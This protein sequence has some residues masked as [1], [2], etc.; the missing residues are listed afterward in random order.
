MVRRYDVWE[1]HIFSDKHLKNKVSTF[2]SLLGWHKDDL[3]LHRLV[4]GDEKWILYN[5]VKRKRRRPAPGEPL[6]TVGKPELHPKK[7]ILCIFWDCKTP[8]FYELLEMNETINTANKRTIWR[9]QFKK[10]IHQLSIEIIF[11]FT[12]IMRDCM[13]QLSP[14]KIWKDLAGV[15]LITH[16]TPQIWHLQTFIYSVC[17]NISFLEKD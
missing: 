2:V 8:I 11:F 13:F 1:P 16:R 12:R 6:Q 15:L 9:Q 14:F 4:A 17:Y 7:Y 3:F 5:N 10:N